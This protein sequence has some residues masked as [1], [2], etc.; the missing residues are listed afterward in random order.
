MPPE[1]VALP[2]IMTLN[3]VE[4]VDS[5]KVVGEARLLAM[6]DK[7]CKDR[8]EPARHRMLDYGQPGPWLHGATGMCIKVSLS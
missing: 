8:N 1:P 3:T 2:D 4:S 6:S 5:I 7:G